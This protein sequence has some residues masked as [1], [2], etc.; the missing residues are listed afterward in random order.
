MFKRF[1]SKKVIWGIFGLTILIVGISLWT[2][3]TIYNTNI[4]KFFYLIIGIIITIAKFAVA[5][6]NKTKKL[7]F[8]TRLLIKRYNKYG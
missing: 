1:G 4:Y 7:N 6:T 3:F 2:L 8:V 5:Y